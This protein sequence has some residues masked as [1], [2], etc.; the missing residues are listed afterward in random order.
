MI[1]KDYKLL[2]TGRTAL[3]HRNTFDLAFNES[4]DIL[5]GTDGGGQE[6]GSVAPA[7]P[8]RGKP[9]AVG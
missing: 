9:P 3:L 5:P 7:W 6:R 8:D 1:Y 2:W 4:D